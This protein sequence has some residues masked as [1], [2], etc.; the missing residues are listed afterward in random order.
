MRKF[1]V[2]ATLS[3]SASLIFGQG[4]MAVTGHDDDYHWGAGGDGITG[5]PGLQISAFLAFARKGSTLPV[6]TIDHGSELTG[7]MTALGIP[8]TNVDPDTAANVTDAMFNHSTYSAVLVA[9]DTSCGG[10]D[11]DP[12]GEANLATHATAIGN[13]LN[14]GGGIIGFAGADSTNYYAF[15][16]QTPTSVGGAPSSGYTQTA[17]GSG[18]GIPAVNGDATHNLFWNPGTHG[19][20]A[21]WQIA[22]VN[23]TTGNGTVPA[24]AAVT[25]ICVSCTVTGGVIGG[26]GGPT[27]PAPSSIILLGSGLALLMFWVASRRRTA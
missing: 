24:P 20:S 1:L 14:A 3:L 2:L 27:T 25:L 23:A 10:C 17:A 13:F 6:L 22:E 8:F 18:N 11:N 19:E 16:P 9:S 4:N 26:G 21:V 5:P 15:L 7:A 12:T